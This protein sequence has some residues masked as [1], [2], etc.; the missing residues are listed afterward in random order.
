MG[1]I[2]NIYKTK[3][4]SC[5]NGGFTDTADQV[6][7]VNVPGPFEPRD[8][9]PVAMLSENAG[10]SPVLV[11]AEQTADGSWAPANPEGM[12]GPMNGGCYA[13]CVDSRWSRSIKGYVAIPIHDRF[14]TPEQYEMLSR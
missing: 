5:S 14:E 8:G 6:L 4:Q 1:L 7:V 13:G 10:G 2:V 3:G 9:E 11:P 12:I